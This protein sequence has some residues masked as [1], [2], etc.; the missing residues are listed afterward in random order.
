VYLVDPAHFIISFTTS[1]ALLLSFSVTIVDDVTIS[2]I[3]DA[4]ASTAA[5]AVV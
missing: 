4:A 3:H 1:S 5:I 2:P